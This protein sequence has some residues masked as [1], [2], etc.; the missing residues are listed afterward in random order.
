MK[1]PAPSPGL[2]IVSLSLLL[3]GSSEAIQDLSAA[4]VWIVLSLSL[5]R[6]F[7]Q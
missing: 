3:K 1:A 4:T 7:S 2:Q 6:R 5:S